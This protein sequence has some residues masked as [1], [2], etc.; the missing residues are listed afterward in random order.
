MDLEKRL[1]TIGIVIEELGCA[2]A[3]NQVI[4]EHSDLV[5]ARMGIPYKER[6]IAVISLIVDGTANE[7]NTLTGKLGRI[8][9]ANV[10]SMLN[11]VS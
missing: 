7:I 3:V 9:G 8:A 5:V 1:G 11:R 6:G 2:Q 10:K 4:H